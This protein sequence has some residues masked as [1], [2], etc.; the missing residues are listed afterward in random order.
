[1][2][3]V[4]VVHWRA[5]ELPERIARVEKAGHAAR[6]F[7]GEGAFDPRDLAAD[8]PDL[9]VIDLGRLP[10]QG[11]DL[12]VWLRRRKATRLARAWRELDKGQLGQARRY[13]ARCDEAAPEETARFLEALEAAQR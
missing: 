10:A 9:F 2:A 1:M 11:R 4:L 6:G 3:C 7:A 8:P 12:G 5:D 13:A